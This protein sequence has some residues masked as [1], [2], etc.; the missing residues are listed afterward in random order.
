[1][2]RLVLFLFAV[3]ALVGGLSW[4]ADRPGSL[5]INWQGYEIETSVFRAVVMLAFLIGLAVLA[6][7]ILVQVWRSPASVGAF[8]NRRRQVRGLDALS[9]GMIAIGAGDRANATRFA[10]QA[11]KSLP[12]EPLTHLLRA[13]AA[14]LSGDRTTAR[15]IFEAMLGAPE[16][17]QLGLRGL[18]LEAEQE[19]EREA[20]R[21]FAERAV[22]LNPKLGWAVDALFD[23]QCKE[24]D[25]D[26]A[27]A[28]LSIAKRHHHLDQVAIARRRAVLMTAQAQALEESQPERAMNLALEAHHLAHDLIPAAAIAGRALAARGNTKRAARVIERTWRRAPHPDLA[29]AYAYARIGDSPRD[30]LDRI[31][32]L[33]HLHQHSAESPIALANAAIEAQVF[34]TA[35]HALEHLRDERMTQRVCT[36]M[37]RIEGEQLGD[38]GLVREWLARA[39]NAP[40]DP[41]WTADGVVS[42]RWEPISPVTGHLDAFQWRVPVEA[43]EG[44]NTALLAMKLEELVKLGASAK[45][46]LE[47]EAVAAGEDARVIEPSQPTHAASS[48]QSAANGA[49]ATSPAA[50]GRTADIPVAS[51]PATPGSAR[52]AEAEAVL[53][54]PM[55]AAATP[56]IQGNAS[57]ATSAGNA[58]LEGAIFAREPSAVLVPAA[59][60]VQSSTSKSGAL[61]SE[62]RR[63]TVANAEAARQPAPKLGGGSADVPAEVS[64]I[65]PIQ[66][67]KERTGEPALFAS[68]HPPDDPGVKT[69]DGQAR[70]TGS[71][72]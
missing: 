55:P 69:L 58:P 20:A 13:Q 67:R 3:A 71:K 1:M 43:M 64:T 9:S 57:S 38:K 26:G 24:R 14:Q 65:T 53:V 45:P 25:W 2:L 37:A 30:R 39:V 44:G 62:A 70:A 68:P 5:M 28:P 40:R 10:V 42:E 27:L 48:P 52:P 4:L 49:S 6:W 21:Q 15:R 32:R 46:A 66:P 35:R 8:F 31:R 17:E 56:A 34:D 33:A 16:T 51:K 11:R 22:G 12:N 61:R 18:F 36:L 41:A 29:V 60:D 47:N 23:L 7:S 19:G 50:Q 54:S 63:R 59:E 72:R